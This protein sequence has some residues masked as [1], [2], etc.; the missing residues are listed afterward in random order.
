MPVCH[1]ALFQL[2]DEDGCAGQWFFACIVDDHACNPSSTCLGG[3]ADTC[4]H[5]REKEK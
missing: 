5:Q 4:E 3:H 2:F 1:N